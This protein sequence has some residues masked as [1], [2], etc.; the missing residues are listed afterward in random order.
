M[1]RD[2]VDIVATEYRPGFIGIGGNDFVI[3]VSLPVITLADSIPPRALMAWD[4]RLLASSQHLTL[5]IGGFHG[6]YPVLEHDASYTSSAQRLGVSVSFKVGLSEKYKP[7][8][9]QVKEVIRKHGLIMQDAEDEL[10]IQAEI[11]AQKAKMFDYDED[12]DEAEHLPAETVPEE[13]EEAVDPG[14]FDRF[15]LSSSL[16]SLMD[17]SFLKIVSL[18]RKFGLGWA[19]AELLN[20]EVEK[21]QRKDDDVFALKENAGIIILTRSP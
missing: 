19:G 17:Q 8:T 5:L 2:F 12:Y 21:S 4:R 15:S 14:R 9:E 6:V 16:E 1:Y 20:S 7:G 13:E 18:R 11:A 10:R 3:S